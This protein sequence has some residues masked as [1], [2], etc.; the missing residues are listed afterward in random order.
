MNEADDRSYIAAFE[1]GLGGGVTLERFRAPRVGLHKM[2][3]VH[4]DSMI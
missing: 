3:I 1:L 2:R 4:H